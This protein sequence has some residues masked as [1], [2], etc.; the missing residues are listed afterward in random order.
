VI[1][2]GDLGGTKC[3]LAYC[4]DDG[5]VRREQMFLCAEASS[6]EDII[7]RF[8]GTDTVKAAAI[9]VAGPVVSGVARITNLPWTIDE[10]A[11]G[12]RLGGPVTLLNDLQATALGMLVLPPDRFAVLHAGDSAAPA[13]STVGV[14]AP[15]T[16]LGEAV[17]VSDGT[18]YRALPSE[19]GHADFAPGTEEELALWRFLCMEILFVRIVSS[20]ETWFLAI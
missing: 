12:A 6:L 5:A 4:T 16:G 14:I 19:G 18:R 8:L 1:L 9:G 20:L 3:V 2:A 13:H 10:R 17:L 7:G 15:G 11:L